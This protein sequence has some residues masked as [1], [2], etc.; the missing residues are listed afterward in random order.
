MPAYRSRTTTHGR[1]M[2]GA[3]GLWR[4][5]GMKDGDFGKPI[6]AVVNSFTQ[7]V[8]GHVHL[9][10]LGQLVAREIEAAGGV[11]KEFN[12]IAVDD[13]IA[14]G[15]DGMLYSL[16]SRELIADSVEYMV[17]AHCADAMVC[18]SNCDKI[19][20]GMLMAAMR[21][22][23]PAVFVSGGPMEAGKVVLHGKKHALDLVDA[24]VAAADDT[25]SDEDVKVIERSACPTCGSCSGMFTANSMNCLTEA[26]GLSL[27]GNGSTLATHADRKRL[28]VEAGHLIVDLAQ[29]WYEQ[30]DANVL[31]RTIAAKPAFE[32]AMAL[33]IAMGG[34]TN[35]VLHILAAAHEG[36]IDFGMDD[37]DRLS[38]KVPVLCKVAP[39]KSDVHMEDVHRAGGIM[40]ILGQLD[41]AGLINRD[42]PTVHAETLGHAIEHWDISR[43]SASK[44]HDFFK[45]APGGVPTQ[46]AFSQA[47]R[48][49][50]LDLDREGGVIRSAETPFSR[51]GGLAVLKGNLA[52]DGCVVKTAGVDE[53]ILKFTGPAVVF[54]SQDAAVKAILSNHVKAGDVVVIRFEGP[55]GGPGMQEMLY[56][57][58]Y[59]KSKGLGKA[60]AL[61]TDGR[62]SG[63]TSGL[64]IGHVS[65]EAEEGGL[66]GLVENGD[67][68]AIDIPNRKIDLVVDEAEITRRRAAMDERFGSSWRPAETR[69]RKVT[70]A[71]RAYAAM[72]TSAAKGAVRH[73]PG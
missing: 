47:S 65:P 54:E 67:T 19:T 12:T 7:F 52:L 36:D 28:F 66:I 42:Q 8:P 20:P 70:M 61:I 23:I 1:N 26:L 46:T 16:P 24:M 69:P 40:A 5:T 31:P 55:R 59:L 13:G 15:H 34:S 17:N 48:W 71:L 37:I 49:E 53:S 27:P 73:V 60:C 11:A 68:I 62:F 21:L 25:M 51:D 33:D 57:T 22:N 4:A 3:R 10:D 35:T 72:A 64:S 45:A 29:R 58:S 39:A 14:M 63:G 41:R 50:D 44:V 43:T 18:I 6:I 32:N 56:P 9:K 30:D 38:R 2:A